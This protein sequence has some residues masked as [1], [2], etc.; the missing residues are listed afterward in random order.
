M[1]IRCL[2]CNDIIESKYIHDLQKC[3]C[4]DCFI[5]GGKE[6]SRIG[7]DFK[8]IS[9]INED[10]TEE[11]MENKYQTVDTLKIRQKNKIVTD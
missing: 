5:D 6:Y 10:G 4:G 7:G 8:F 11:K 2:K 1:K 9:I 3:K